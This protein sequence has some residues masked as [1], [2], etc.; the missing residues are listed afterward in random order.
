[1]KRSIRNILLAVISITCYGNAYAQG[2]GPPMLTDDPATLNKHQFEINTSV[3]SQVTKE[4]QLAV[5]YVDANYGVND[6]FQLKI[7]M[8]YQVTIDQQDHSSGKFV[9]PLFGVKYHFVKEEKYFL[10]A[11]TYP[12]FTITGTQKGFLLPLLLSKTIGKF[13]IG[14]ELGYL[15][16]EKDSSSLINGNLLS[17]KLSKRWELMG[18]FFLQKSYHPTIATTGFMNY[19][20][21]YTIN[22]TFTFIGSM[23]TQVITPANQE[24]QYYFS[25]IGI[26]SDF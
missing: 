16:V 7:E 2:G 9:D 12:Q 24:R 11:T 10:S 21:R 5:P 19:G 25:F 6:N 13:V 26:Q 14:E 22:K 17:Y 1:M 23:G 20:C 15:F 3:N 18:E 4:V 8:P